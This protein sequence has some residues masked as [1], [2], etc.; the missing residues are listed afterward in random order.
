MLES[1]HPNIKFTYEKEVNNT[2]PFLDAL[3]I[4]NSDDI[5]RTVY[6]KETNNDLYLQWLVY[7]YLY[8]GKVEQSEL[9]LIEPILS[10]PTIV[11]YSKN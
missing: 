11:I 8:L 4:R 10:A 7:T 3:Y 1:F 6:R 2:L 5:H 9:W